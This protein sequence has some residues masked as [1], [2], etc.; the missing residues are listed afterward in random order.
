MNN[1]LNLDSDWY[2]LNV[3]GR[4]PRAMIQHGPN[5][6]VRIAAITA[7]GTRLAEQAC[8]AIIDTGA[9]TSCV[10]PH[11]FAKLAAGVRGVRNIAHVYGSVTSES[12]VRASVSW[13]PEVAFDREF[14]LLEHL[15]HYGV[16]IGRDILCECR[17]YLDIKTAY[18]CLCAPKRG[19][20]DQS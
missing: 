19:E 20:A 2:C 5:I 12:T 1:P 4:D 9:E 16:L 13:M 11:I 6:G 7:D 17:F 15:A 8:G 10:S 18:F 14:S 3:Q